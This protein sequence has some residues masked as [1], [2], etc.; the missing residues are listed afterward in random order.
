MKPLQIITLLG[1]QTKRRFFCWRIRRL[2][3]LIK[4][5]VKPRKLET[6]SQNDIFCCVYVVIPRVQQYHIADLFSAD[7]DQL[8][9]L[10]VSS[11]LFLKAN[12]AFEYSRFID[13]NAAIVKLYTPQSTIMCHN[14]KLTLRGRGLT[15]AMVHGFYL[16]QQREPTYYENPHFDDKR[17]PQIL[18]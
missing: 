4:Q 12:Q 3:D 5:T 14:S 9:T 7:P 8:K 17:L 2:N 13:D 10:L 6:S 15:M 1:H 18:T 11:P 16:I